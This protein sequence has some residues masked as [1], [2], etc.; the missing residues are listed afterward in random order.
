[1]QTKE[2]IIIGG[3]IVVKT[4]LFI[5]EPERES[6]EIGGLDLPVVTDIRNRCTLHPWFVTQRQDAFS[7][8]M[9]GESSRIRRL[10]QKRPDPS[11]SERCY[12]CRVLALPKRATNEG[13]TRLIVRDAHIKGEFDAETMLEVKWESTINRVTGTAVHPRPR[14]RVTAGTEFEFEMIFRIFDSTDK[15]Q[16]D[17]LTL[18]KKFLR[19]F[20]MLEHDTIGGSGSRGCGKIEFKDITITGGNGNAGSLFRKF[21]IAGSLKGTPY[22]VLFFRASQGTYRL[23]A[24]VRY[25]LR[26]FLLDAENDF[27]GTFPILSCS[28]HSREA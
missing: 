14:E 7:Q 5:L 23:T 16:P 11:A 21:R 6:I 4:G 15:V 20:E 26:S 24:K 12:I 17:D 1:M 9:E 10:F 2:T 25:A 28:S 19:S 8:R 13:L 27:A 18:F 22:V 3:T